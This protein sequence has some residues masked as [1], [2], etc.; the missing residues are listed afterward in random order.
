MKD[1]EKRLEKLEQAVHVGEEP[2]V[3][4]VVHSIFPDDG[5]VESGTIEIR[6]EEVAG[7][8]EPLRPGTNFRP[9]RFDAK[10]RGWLLQHWDGV[11]REVQELAIKLAS[12]KG[13]ERF[14]RALEEKGVVPGMQDF[15]T[16]S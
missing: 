3:I 14:L 5:S 11:I 6:Q 2:T 12:E 8:I 7:L 13:Q 1:V 16:D 9:I 4:W 15:S 10:T